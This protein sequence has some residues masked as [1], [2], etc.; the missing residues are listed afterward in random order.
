M[1]KRALLFALIISLMAVGLFG[2]GKKDNAQGAGGT[3]SKDYVY[4]MEK[5]AV[6]AEDEDISY[7]I[8]A[9]DL[10]YA[11]GYDWAEDGSSFSIH[12]YELNSDGTVGQRYTIRMGSN[13]G[14][15]SINM[16]EESNFYCIKNFY[17]PVG[18]EPDMK[19]EGGEASGS[20]GAGEN[21]SEEGAGGDDAGGEG[22]GEDAGGTGGE[23]AGEDA[24]GTGGEAANGEGAGE[25][26]GGA[27]NGEAAG[28]STGMIQPRT[29]DGAEEDS[30]T[31]GREEADGEEAL[32]EENGAVG[33]MADGTVV[34]DVAYDE[35]YEEVE[36][37]DDYYLS[38]I[39]LAGEELFSVKLNDVP[40]LAA[41]GEE[42]GYFYVGNMFLAQGDGLYITI[43]GNIVKFD[44]EGNYVATVATSDDGENPLVGANLFPLEDGRVLAVVYEEDGMGY[45]QADLEK[46]T[47]GETYKIPGRSYDCSYFSGKGYDLYLANNYGLYGYNLGDADKTQIMSFIDSDFGF[48]N[49]YQVLGISDTEF[50][51]VY[52]DNESMMGSSLAKFT[53]IPPAEV[54]E[55]QEFTLAMGDTNWNVRQAVVKFNQSS[56]TIRIRLTDYNTLYGSDEDWE[57]GLARLNADIASGKVPDI[58]VLDDSMPV[59]SYISKGLFEDLKPYIEKDEA[60][61]LESFMPNVIEAYS[62]EGKLYSL[63]PSY[64]IQ[65]VAVK[66]A[67]VGD[68]TWWSVQEAMDIL[69][70]KPGDTQFL[71]TVTRRDM[72]EYC[73]SMSSSQFI[74]W[75]SGKCNF[76]SD[77]F[78]KMLEFIGQFPEEVDQAIYTDEFWNNYDTMWREGRALA[79][80]LNIGDFRGYNI[81]EK[82]TFGE[83]ITLIG[84]PSAEGSGSVIWP[85]LQIAL[86]SKCADKDGAWQ[87]LRTFLTDEYQENLYNFPLSVKL[88]DE[89]GQEATKRPYYED[90]NGN[91]TEYDDTYWL[92]GVDITI[93]PMTE[94]EVEFLKNW[95]KSVDK[96][97]KMDETLINIITEEAAP[98][99][100]GQKSAKDVA[101]IIQSRVQIYVN[102]N[103]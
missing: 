57:A 95:I 74:D 20:A 89:A 8:S 7:L 11:Y 75:D 34:A 61:S 10:A 40:E 53:K 22:A 70:S 32:G 71:A 73:I 87:F 38:K 68:K 59:D 4:K 35:E 46:G 14:V 85:D 27:V 33:D 45:A 26:T 63:V 83:K 82:G 64:S 66:T 65:T 19:V 97:Y 55:K 91:K 28:V 25:N 80:V 17:Y 58:V 54:K 98:Y 99:Y 43:L 1:K 93:P 100:A 30:E 37:V 9:G 23:G 31:E 6:G 42:N 16:D 24:G 62:V 5:L 41:I 3:A 94:Q 103:R 60:F 56:D 15:S 13:V 81:A 72:M 92:N 90:E 77:D 102:E 84:F 50:F 52:D 88:L 51:G 79:S 67:D 18:E 44:L 47:V 76:D 69:A 48:S 49:F 96:A 36:Y 39:T 78:I 101:G 21:T 86:S 29:A 12:F 2:C